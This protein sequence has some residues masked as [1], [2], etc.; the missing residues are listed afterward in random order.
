[1]NIMFALRGSPHLYDLWEDKY[2]CDGW[3]YK[4]VLPYFLKSEHNT[5]SKLDSKHHCDKGPLKISHFPT[6]PFM[7]FIE[8]GLNE[9]GIPFDHGIDFPHKPCLQRV[10]GTVY[11]GRRYS[12][13]KA[14]IIPIQ[15]RTNFK[16]VK[17]VVVTRV[18]FDGKKAIGVEF[19]YKG[20]L[21]V[22]Y[23]RK[24]VILSAGAVGTPLILQ[25]SGIGLQEDLNFNNVT[26]WLQLPVGRYLQDHLACWLW[27]SLDGDIETIGQYLSD[28]T[29][30][31]R[32]PR[33]GS[34]TGLGTESLTGFF[35]TPSN[36]RIHFECYFFHFEKQSPFLASIVE[37]IGY[38]PE[39][40]NTILE[41]NRNQALLLIVPSQ[42]DPKSR[43]F[44][45]SNGG[46]ATTMFDNPH[47]FLNN[48]GHPYDNKSHIESMQ[49]ILTFPNVETW[50]KANV[51]FLQ[52][53]ICQD[54]PNITSDEY[55][56][57]YLKKMASSTFHLVGT[58]NQF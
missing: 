22:A 29:G 56:N 28:I 10:Q 53:P 2:K 20:M 8:V 35:S 50:K 37:G 47:I 40:Q 49:H 26:S 41:A 7:G 13:S 44:V 24:E 58:G 12:V 36:S 1:M 51:S 6:D 33:T 14:Y 15:H 11:D 46:N 55:C 3:S 32:E 17:C 38:L 42:L 30:Y 52:L 23:A 45:R 54:Y 48:L 34:F 57:C 21:R 27:F 4:D 18:I 9:A 19:F 39:I 5:D 43:G 31:F 16:L 25:Q